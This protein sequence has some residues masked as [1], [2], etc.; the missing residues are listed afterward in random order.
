M[1]RFLDDCGA[2]LR[3]RSLS[4]IRVSE[5]KDGGEVETLEFEPANPCQNTYSVA[6]TFAA[7]GIGLL[8]DRGAIRLD[9]RVCS[10]LADEIAPYRDKI[11]PR[12][13]SSTVEMALTHRLG[14]P[15]G[16]L[17]IDVN[18]SSLFGEDFLRFMLTSPLDYPPGEGEKYSDGAFYLVS[19]LV[20][21]RAGVPLD[22]YLW[23]ELFLPL[24][25]QEAAWSRCPGGH[26]MGATG[27]YLHSSDMVKLA[28]L[29]LDGGLWRGRRI[30]SGEWVDLA[31]NRGFAWGWDREHR[32][33]SK[34]G[35]RGQLLLFLPETRRAV[36]IQSFEGA[37]GETAAFARD[38]TGA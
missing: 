16:F 3:E 2:Y 14:L 6:K 26:A 8:Y 29:Y 5:I 19:R 24:G 27:L 22:T 7:T 4:V 1:S 33:C 38:Y 30:L 18:P 11:D 13:F 32:M 17:D 36:A 25:F 12:W 20:E 28:A 23:R 10:V 31:V 9:E 15:G 35:M 34:G 37:V 21:K